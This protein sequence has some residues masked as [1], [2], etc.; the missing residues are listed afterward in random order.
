MHKG[1]SRSN[2]AGTL[3][4]GTEG[5]AITPFVFRCQGVQSLRQDPP[6]SLR[7]KAA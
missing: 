6:I 1:T 3:E 2:A 7:D 4:M 5:V